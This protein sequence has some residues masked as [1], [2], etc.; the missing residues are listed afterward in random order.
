[1]LLRHRSRAGRPGSRHSRRKSSSSEWKAT[2]SESCGLVGRAGRAGRVRGKG[3]CAAVSTILRGS[4]SGGGF[5]GRTATAAGSGWT[6]WR[7]QECSAQ[8]LSRV[9]CCTL[10]LTSKEKK[11]QAWKEVALHPQHFSWPAG[12]W[13]CGS[14]TRRAPAAAGKQDCCLNTAG[15]MYLLVCIGWLYT[16][17]AAD[18][19]PGPEAAAEGC[20]ALAWSLIFYLSLTGLST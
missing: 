3:T 1:M 10:C 8:S 9:L 18:F 14:D 15:H 12:G 13:P 5:A 2:G 20:S 11:S 17:L 19:G 7:S 4:C 16:P 6:C